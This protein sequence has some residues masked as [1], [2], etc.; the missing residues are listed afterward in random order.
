MSYICARNGFMELHYRHDL[1]LGLF[2]IDWAS[3]NLMV[4]WC[5][6]RAS[7]YDQSSSLGLVNRVLHCLA[8]VDAGCI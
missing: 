1:S 6:S 5:N 4:R 7:T 8:G 3:L 2:F